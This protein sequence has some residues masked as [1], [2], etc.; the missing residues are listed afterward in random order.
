MD[1]ERSTWHLCCGCQ[2]YPQQLKGKQAIISLF[3]ETNMSNIAMTPKLQDLFDIITLTKKIIACV[4]DERFNLQT[5]ASALN[6]I[7]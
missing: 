5:C 3:Q 4:K 2:L 7:I 1:V 6:S